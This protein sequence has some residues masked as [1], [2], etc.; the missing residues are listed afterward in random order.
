MFVKPI[1]ITKLQLG[2]D[3]LKK[4][5]KK[6][7]QLLCLKLHACNTIAYLDIAVV[8]NVGGVK[9]LPF[10]KRSTGNEH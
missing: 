1:A 5:K 2:S 10:L 9:C 3:I 4:K 7:I 8:C 6:R